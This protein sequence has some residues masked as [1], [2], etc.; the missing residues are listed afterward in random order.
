MP[1]TWPFLISLLIKSASA[2]ISS[3]KWRNPKMI[4]A[5]IVAQRVED[6]KCSDQ[7]E[8]V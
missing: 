6:A 7:L 8:V 3:S 2:E 4:Y 1:E 5:R